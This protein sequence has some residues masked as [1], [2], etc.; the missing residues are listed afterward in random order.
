ML[1]LFLFLTPLLDSQFQFPLIKIN[2]TGPMGVLLY[3]FYCDYNFRS[4]KMF[5]HLR[6]YAKGQKYVLLD[7]VYV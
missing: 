4:H 6:P 7:T 1:L 3:L 2:I 5:V